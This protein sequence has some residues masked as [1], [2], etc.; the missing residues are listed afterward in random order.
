[1]LP[2]KANSVTGFLESNRESSFDSVRKVKFLELAKQAAE[3][4]AMPDVASI[5]RHVGISTRTYWAHID[6]DPK[7]AEA[8]E[9]VVDI[10]ESGL[11]TKMYEFAQRP[12][13]YMDRIT[14]LKNMRPQRWD[15]EHRVRI[16]HDSRPQNSLIDSIKTAID[17]DIVGE[18][19]PATENAPAT[20]PQDAESH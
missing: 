14:W 18:L 12:S 11:V 8:W 3:N 15:L 20:R 13:N 17:A 16:V 9:E 2:L 7:F 4:H 6:V 1:V 5:C 19:G 10:C